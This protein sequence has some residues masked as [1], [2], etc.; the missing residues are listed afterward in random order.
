MRQILVSYARSQHS[1]KR[2]G[3]AVKMELDEA[4]I[5]SPEQSQEIVELH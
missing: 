4:A 3:G 5:V 1:Q 2:G